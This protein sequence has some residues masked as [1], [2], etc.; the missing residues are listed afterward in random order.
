[1]KIRLD[2]PDRIYSMLV[3]EA[4]KEGIGLNELIVRSAEKLLDDET[5]PK[6]KRKPPVIDC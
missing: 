3:K 1:M 4:L 6:P 2:I 5:M